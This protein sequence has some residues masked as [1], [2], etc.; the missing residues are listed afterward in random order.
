MNELLVTSHDTPLGAF[1]FVAEID[2]SGL[3]TVLSSGWQT[4]S[5]TVARLK[6]SK[7]T[8]VQKVKS[9]AVISESVKNYFDGDVRAF[10]EVLSRQ[11]GGSFMQEVWSALAHVPAGQVVSYAQLAQLSGRPKAVRAAASACATNLV[12]PFI[13]CHR[14]IR[15]DGGLGGYY[16]G[17]DKKVWLLKHEGVEV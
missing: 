9:I 16:Y 2:A 1:H 4:Q 12:A 7:V 13:P 3:A 15:T 8:G 5:E 11:T 6:L 10:D 17:L 14:V